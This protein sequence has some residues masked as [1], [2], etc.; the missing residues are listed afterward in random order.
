MIDSLQQ[1]IVSV[2]G[3]LKYFANEAV[4]N[5]TAKEALPYSS[6]IFVTF[7]DL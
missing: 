4:L 1:L 6:K 7:K 3:L 5:I 2:F